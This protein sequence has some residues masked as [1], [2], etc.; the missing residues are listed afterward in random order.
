MNDME[1]KIATRPA[2]AL[3]VAFFLSLLLVLGLDIGHGV[4]ARFHERHQPSRDN[5]LDGTYAK[6]VDRWTQRESWA[7]RQM[8]PHWNE[9][10]LGLFDET[11]GKVIAGRDDWLY[12][13]TSLAPVL[14]PHASRS[15]IGMNGLIE[16]VAAPLAGTP[17]RFRVLVMPAKWRLYPTGLRGGVEQID[18]LR[19]AL[20][21]RAQNHLTTQGID[22]PNVLERLLARRD[23]D[24]QQLLYPPN[25]T[26]FSQA[27]FREMVIEM[28][29]PWAG[30]DA[31]LAAQRIDALP[32]EDHVHGGDLCR[33]M[34][35]RSE[36]A[37]GR[38]YA[39]DESKILAPP[40]FDAPGA[41]IV[42]LGDSFFRHYDGLFQRLIQAATGMTVDA[43]YAG[44]RAGGLA[45]SRL[46]QEYGQR[47]P[48]LILMGFTERRFASL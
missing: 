45:F 30:V 21:E 43:R 14:E 26:H 2:L 6:Q 18:P 1:Q 44:F 37:A 34:G 47:P 20:Y 41:D 7:M 27:G 16:Q 38:R 33:L 10:M 36:S 46:F 4:F 39:F 9:T 17:V 28:I 5:L 40:S 8:R 35:L 32:R 24:P 42:I 11:P 22:A 12:L 23:S 15:W 25:D 31:E 3:I 48:K 19:R 29:A 13:R